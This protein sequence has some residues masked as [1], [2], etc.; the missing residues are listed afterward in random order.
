MPFFQT[1]GVQRMSVMIY[2]CK[3]C[4][5]EI[6]ID[7]T[8]TYAAP[9]K[10]KGTLQYVHNK[11]WEEWLKTSKRV[12][13]EICYPKHYEDHENHQ[14]GAQ[15]QQVRTDVFIVML[16]MAFF[17]TVASAMMI[18][19]PH[20]QM[21]Y[22][23]LFL[24][25]VFL[26]FNLSIA[27][28]Q[29]PNMH[30]RYYQLVHYMLGLFNANLFVFYRQGHLTMMMNI[31]D[32]QTCFEI[33]IVVGLFAFGLQWFVRRN[34]EDRPPDWNLV[35]FLVSIFVWS[36]WLKQIILRPQIIN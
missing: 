8:T 17:Y 6:Q 9:C 11:C 35:C 14:D 33:V 18:S 26:G 10:C 28:G 15:P 4:W 7:Q 24:L 30:P 22:H 20:D 34:I 25:F 21:L 29:F 1:Y 13:C 5:E 23:A 16:I 27:V 2:E 31:V 32:Y 36:A 19:N 12:L 3:I